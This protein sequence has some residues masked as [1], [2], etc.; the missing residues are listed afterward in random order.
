MSAFIIAEAGVNH[1]G[2]LDRAIQM[3]D[4]AAEA[5]ADAIKFQTFKAE[6]LVTAAAP[7]AA[8]QKAKTDPR[9]G[10]LDM[11]QA[12]ELDE[13]AHR[14]LR[15]RCAAMG[16]EF[17]SSPFD[18]PSV[19]F[20]A[21]D[22]GVARLKLGSGEITNALLISAAAQTGLPLIISTGMSV[23]EDITACLGFVGSVYLD[24]PMPRTPAEA[25][26]AGGEAD[27]LSALRDRVSLLHCT[28]DYPTRP[29]DVNLF[30]MDTLRDTFGLPTGLSDHTAGIAVSVAAI[31]RGA[32][33]VE[34]HFTLDRSLPGPDHA[35]SLSAA[36]LK[37]LVSAIRQVEAALGSREK[38][39]TIAE[40][41]T[42]MV[43]RRCLVAAKP[44]S[45]GE[46]FTSVNLTSKRPANGL[47]PLYSWSLLGKQARHS[48]D[49]DMPLREDELEQ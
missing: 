11:L 35:A 31:A 1:N 44:I 20:L 2:N 26:A 36:E 30:A 33:V 46:V 4:V 49:P 17:M 28:S 48:Y 27:V 38:Q 24:R 12:L 15:D 40:K 25:V 47:S 43:A 14:R 8:Y 42:A 41:S 16:V 34:K 37:D 3:I 5:G 22:I 19:R 10:Q 9:E 39:P 32:T 45:A 18:E 7:K 23:I 21:D 6:N 13:V 29:E